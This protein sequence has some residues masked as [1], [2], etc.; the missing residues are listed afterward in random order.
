ME[1]I[2]K[3]EDLSGYGVDTIS[4]V[5]DDDIDKTYNSY[6]MWVKTGDTICESDFEENGDGTYSI[7][8]DYIN[9]DIQNLV[10]EAWDLSRLSL[11][12]K[13]ELL[14]MS[15]F[16]IDKSDEADNVEVWEIEFDPLKGFTITESEPVE[17]GEQY[18]Y[19]DG[20]N[21]ETILLTN[22][23][24]NTFCEEITSEFEGIRD[25]WIRI[26]TD[27]NHNSTRWRELLYDPDTD[28]L[29][30]YFTTLWQ[31]ESSQYRILSE[32]FILDLESE[33]YRGEKI[34]VKDS[35]ICLVYRGEVYHHSVD[36]IIEEDEFSF[37]VHIDLSI[38]RKAIRKR[39]V[40]RITERFAEND[41]RLVETLPLDKIFVTYE[42]SINAGNCE[43][44]SYRVKN[45]IAEAESIDGLYE[46]RADKL[47]RY[48]D[49][50]YTRRAIL[51]AYRKKKG[52]GGLKLQS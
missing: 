50:N 48:R 10:G 19:W 7:D 29:W 4:F 37:F 35:S 27:K 26:G 20:S 18:T 46:Y 15:E 12:Q 11:L 33:L 17:I 24:H 21:Y 23:C 40:K 13:N 49:D 8:E 14:K 25:R 42:D 3:F 47:L 16:E 30:R 51:E 39:R 31:G 9:Y 52:W 44:I 36:E 38:A 1:R 5:D 2:F 41:Y 34:E 45:E 28:T 22:D 32:N 6:G 43:E